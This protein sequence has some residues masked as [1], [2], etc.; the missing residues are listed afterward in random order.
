MA[1]TRRCTSQYKG[2][3]QE[4]VVTEVLDDA[5]DD[6]SFSW[7]GLSI[8][9]DNDVAPFLGE[10]M[11]TRE[12]IVTLMSYVLG[13]KN[14]ELLVASGLEAVPKDRRIAALQ[15]LQDLGW[16]GHSGFADFE[17][18]YSLTR[19][20]RR[21]ASERPTL[22]TLE[23]ALRS[24]VEALR[25]LDAA[26]TDDLK[27]ALSNLIRVECDCGNWDSA[28][29]YCFQLRKLAERTKDIQMLAIAVCSQ[30][31][32]EAVQNRWDDALESYLEANERFMEVGDRRG[33]AEV[34][35]AM[36]V[37]Y[38]NKGD[39]ASAIRCFESSMSMA[40]LIGDRA[41]EA[42]ADGNLA[43]IYD[44]EGKPEESE[45]AHKRCLNFFLEAGDMCSVA[46]TSNNLG[47]LYMARERFQVAAEYF[48]KAIETSRR[49]RSN[50]ILGI[51]LVNGGYCYARCG[52]IAR[53][54]SYTDEAVAILRESNDFNYLA[55]AYRNYGCLD[56]RTSR[57]ETAF[58]WFEKSIRTAQASGVEDTLAACCYEY[59]MA[60]IKSA[61][62]LRLA[63]RLLKKATSIYR[64]LGNVG[65]AEAVERHLSAA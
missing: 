34:N 20:G 63:K 42:K 18:S 54:L 58:E 6:Q 56:F 9:E 4:T 45:K 7:T 24:H 61:T 51:A 32:I 64:R 59:G 50:G 26:S 48:E 22:A 60:L 30:G 49:S 62:D 8:V 23:P 11:A 47:V 28:L 2:L 16:I 25:S 52:D 14:R 33:V 57:F 12:Q 53:A 19:E 10:R 35:R 38:A 21:V 15:G 13:D 55:L 17:E 40:R 41:L 3:P 44:L 36:G 39:H 37:V 31:K 29:I 46:R 43:N 27:K 5:V 1:G 65:R